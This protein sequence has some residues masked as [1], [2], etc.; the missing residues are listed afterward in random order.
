VTLLGFTDLKLE[1]PC[2]VYELLPQGSLRDC[3][4][5]LEETEPIK[6]VVRL[7]IAWQIAMALAYVHHPS[8]N[9]PITLHFDIK[10]ANILLDDTYRAKLADFG[11]MKSLGKLKSGR[12]EEI[13]GTNGFIFFLSFV[14]K[15]Y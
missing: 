12:M 3:L 1:R 8:P 13:L 5:R 14:F 15:L 9:S 7:K 10:S 11:I 4:D 6:W 2:L